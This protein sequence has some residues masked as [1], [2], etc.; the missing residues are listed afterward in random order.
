MTALSFVVHG[1]SSLV[2]SF[3]WFIPFLCIKRREKMEEKI[4]RSREDQERDG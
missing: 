4:K 3:V 2:E 1:R